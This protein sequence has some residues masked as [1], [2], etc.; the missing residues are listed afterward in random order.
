MECKRLSLIIL[1]ILKTLCVEGE[2][3]ATRAP[4]PEI[5]S[6]NKNEKN[7]EKAERREESRMLKKEVHDTGE[8]KMWY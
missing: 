5:D 4:P 8:G 1:L 3:F 6:A 2:G 7:Q